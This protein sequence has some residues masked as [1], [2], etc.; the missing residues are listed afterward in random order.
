ML[1]AAGGLLSVSVFLLV[2]RVDAYYAYLSWLEETRYAAHG[3]GPEDLWWAPVSFWHVLLSVVAALL[4]H[5]YLATRRWS[6]FLLWQVIGLFSLLGWGLT[7][8]VGVGLDCLMRGSVGPLVHALSYVEVS[9]LA[10]YVSAVCACNVLYGSALQASSRQYVAE[11]AFSP[12][13]GITSECTRPESPYLSC[14]TWR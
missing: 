1:G 4:T 8:S 6:P 14:E 13:Y 9:Y 7:F 2:A 10:K 11:G 5:R 3:T 12:Q